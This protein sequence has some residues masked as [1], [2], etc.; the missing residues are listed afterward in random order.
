MQHA[1][2]RTSA[3]VWARQP[4]HTQQSPALKPVLNLQDLLSITLALCR[5]KHGLRLLKQSGIKSDVS[6]FACP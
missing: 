5:I 3:D 2:M 1:P 4:Q 6:G